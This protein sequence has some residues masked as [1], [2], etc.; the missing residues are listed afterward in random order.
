MGAGWRGKDLYYEKRPIK[1]NYKE[2][3]LSITLL[4]WG[5]NPGERQD[6]GHTKHKRSALHI[7]RITKT[8]IYTYDIYIYVQYIRVYTYTCI[9][10]YIYTYIHTHIYAYIHVHIYAY[11]CMCMKVHIWYIYI[12]V[13]THIP[14]Y[15]FTYIYIYIQIYIKFSRVL[16]WCDIKTSHMVWQKSVGF[17]HSK[18]SFATE[19]KKNMSILQKSPKKSR[20]P[21]NCCHLT[22][23]IFENNWNMLDNLIQITPERF[24]IFFVLCQ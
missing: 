13:F 15:L 4:I 8:C 10:I 2:T 1:E 9:Y 11:I 7:W 18:G 16:Q 5:K 3:P 6:E 21:S 14:I 12:Y 23:N 22:H 20:K 19:P 24:T 17:P